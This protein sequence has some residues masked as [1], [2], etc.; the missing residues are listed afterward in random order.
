MFNRQQTQIWNYFHE[1]PVFL[2]ACAVCSGQGFGFCPKNP[3]SGLS[4]LNEEIFF[5]FYGMNLQDNIQIR[6]P[7][8]PKTQSPGC[9]LPSNIST[10]DN[11]VYDELI[12]LEFH[13][14]TKAVAHSYWLYT[15]TVISVFSIMVLILDG[16]SEHVTHAWK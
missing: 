3:D 5:K 9:K 14:F 10:M 8:W 11:I 1:K 2:H 12:T 4:T 15:W 13:C 16:Y 6:I 7:I